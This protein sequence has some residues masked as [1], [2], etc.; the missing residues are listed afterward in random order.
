VFSHTDPASEKI[1]SGGTSQHLNVKKKNMFAGYTYYFD[2]TVTASGVSKTIELVYEIDQ[3]DLVAA[4]NVPSGETPINQL[5]SLT[6]ANSYD[7]D[8]AST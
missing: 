2:V 4:I 7:P 8:D 1:V 5:L 3:S 6:G